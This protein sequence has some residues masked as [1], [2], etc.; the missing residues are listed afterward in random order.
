MLPSKFPANANYMLLLII[1]VATFD[2]I[3]EEYVEYIF[4]FPQAEP[5]SLAFAQ[6]D[7]ESIYA[8]S[9]LSTEFFFFKFY[10]C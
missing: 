8:V 6:C 10:L 1:E 2:L 3:P 4:T 7:Y 9:N 5:Y